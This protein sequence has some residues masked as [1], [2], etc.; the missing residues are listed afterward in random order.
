MK[1]TKDGAVK[2]V[3]E[4]FKDELEALGWKA[5]EKKAVADKVK[6]IKRKTKKDK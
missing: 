3:S 4:A 2:N 1:F 6:T 5:E